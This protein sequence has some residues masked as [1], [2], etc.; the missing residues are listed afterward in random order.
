MNHVPDLSEFVERAAPRRLGLRPARGKAPRHLVMEVDRELEESD[1]ELLETARLGVTSSPLQR[2]RDSHHRLAEALASGM[3][4]IE[5]SAV[6]GYDP[7]R[8]S[9]LKADPAFKEL[10]EF[11][12]SARDGVFRDFMERMKN[13]AEDA[14]QELHIRLQDSPE[15]V[16]TSELLAILNST[17]DRTGHGP[18]STRRFEGQVTLTADQI[19][20]IKGAA[21]EEHRGRVSHRDGT[22][23]GQVIDITPTEAGEGDS[24]EP[25]S[26]KQGG[27]EEL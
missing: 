8:I 23:R 1:L 27:G 24:G 4:N 13:L 21:E 11:Y 17:A 19:E 5:A 15:S 25:A 20:A 9:L 3:S 18:T 12:R 10:L 16:K 6:T 14:L 7:A 22:P 2:I 26:G